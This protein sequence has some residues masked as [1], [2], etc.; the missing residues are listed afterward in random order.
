MSPHE[1]KALIRREM[2]E[3]WLGGNPHVIHETSHA[4]R[5][6][7]RPVR[8]KTTAVEDLKATR[9]SVRAAFSEHHITVEH[10]IVE[11]DM[12]AA[13]II[14]KG[15]HTGEFMGVKPTGKEIKVT[16]NGIY[17]IENGKIVEDWTEWDR[18][19]ILEQLGL[20]PPPPGGGG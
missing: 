15:K 2:E 9:A 3:T 17:R 1:I 19:S 12:A 10:L 5:V 4:H 6:T 8:T 18:L 13:R 7:H 20:A 14:V 11:G 16:A